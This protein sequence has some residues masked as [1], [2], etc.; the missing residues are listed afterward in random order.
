MNRCLASLSNS[1][2]RLLL[3]VAIALPLLP[4]AAHAAPVTRDLFFGGEGSLVFDAASGNGAWLGTIDESPFPFVDPSLNLLSY[5]SFVFDRISG[6]FGGSFEMTLA[7]DFSSTLSGL[8]DGDLLQGDF[9][10]GG[11]LFVNYTISD[12]SGQ[13]N[14]ASGF[15][16]SLLDFKAPDGGFRDYTEAGVLSFSV[17]EPG[18]LAL[19]ALA[20]LLFAFTARK[21]A[22]VKVEQ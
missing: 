20:L 2:R 12:G 1:A 14:K 19:A 6:H 15:G 9:A 7:N 13:F 17:P 10:S 5:V 4:A 8:V 22:K 16:I 21:P 3:C 11:Q 18:A